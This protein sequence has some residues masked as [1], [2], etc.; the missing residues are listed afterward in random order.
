MKKLLALVMCVVMILAVFTGCKSNNTASLLENGEKIKIGIAAY[1]NDDDTKEI[2][3]GLEEGFDENK[4]SKNIEID[5]QNAANDDKKLEKICSD[6]IKKSDILI[7]I[8][9]EAS[10]CAASVREKSEV[11][12][13]FVNVKNPITSN[14]MSNTITPSKN[15]TGVM[16]NV[17]PDCVF[18]FAA[19]TLGGQLKKV[20]I[21]YNTSEINP[22]YE[23]NELK[24]YLNS[25]SIKCY[26]GVIANVFDAQQSVIKIVAEKTK[27][28]MQ[29]GSD[30]ENV[31]TAFFISSDEI[32][33]QSIPGI[34]S[35]IKS[36][37]SVAFLTSDAELP[38]EHFYRITPVY[39]SLGKKCADLVYSYASGT[40]M[41]AISAVS[42]DEYNLVQGE[43][44]N[45]EDN[46]E[47]TSGEN[48]SEDNKTAENKTE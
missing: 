33:K 24:D 27:A 16:G 32:T 25:N 10:V 35:I 26:D 17:T 30:N 9:T 47:N 3:S 42:S 36:T 21:I 14:L 18:S 12:I 4:I 13:F 15:I 46:N 45:E 6:L 48:Q 28:Q 44:S 31:R 29:N 41:L 43:V 23:V 40:D 37:N 2:K 1:T 11:P 20:G 7:T 34:A 8:G 19:E 39:K 5:Y 22:S 38:N